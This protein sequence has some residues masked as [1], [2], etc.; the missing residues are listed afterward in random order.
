MYVFD[1]G[2]YVIQLRSVS[3]DQAADETAL[4]VGKLGYAD[5]YRIAKEFSISPVLAKER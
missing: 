5:S 4:L 2:V 1:S 3:V